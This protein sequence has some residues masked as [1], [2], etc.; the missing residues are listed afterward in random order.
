[1]KSW[2]RVETH[3]H[4]TI[5]TVMALVGVVLASIGWFSSIAPQAR[6]VL[7]ASGYGL[8]LI[9]FVAS[10]SLAVLSRTRG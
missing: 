5:L 8:I 7:T 6:T 3:K 9:G 2:N 1:L 4:Y 10:L